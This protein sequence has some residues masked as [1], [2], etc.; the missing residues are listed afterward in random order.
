MTL[1]SDG[2]DVLTTCLQSLG[3]QHDWSRCVLP[4]CKILSGHFILRE[5]E[6]GGMLRV[7]VCVCHCH[8]H[9]VCV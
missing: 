6:W 3:I 9:D 8:C 2:F 4:R 7:C 1:Q 5:P